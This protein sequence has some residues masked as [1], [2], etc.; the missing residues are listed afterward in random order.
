MVHSA[1]VPRGRSWCDSSGETT[2]TASTGAEAP[3]SGVSSVTGPAGGGDLGNGTRTQGQGRVRGI[4]GGHYF[5]LSGS[6]NAATKL[7]RQLLE[8]KETRRRW[9]AGRRRSGSV[10]LPGDDGSVRKAGL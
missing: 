1:M 8:T 5:Y 7:T 4:L 9:H 3:L 2:G 10:K 6:K